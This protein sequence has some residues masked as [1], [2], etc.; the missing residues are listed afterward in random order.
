MGCGRW[1]VEGVGCALSTGFL[2]W[3]ACLRVRSGLVR[4]R[5]MG[6]CVCVCVLLQGRSVRVGGDVM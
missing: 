5:G 3:V 6:V 4:G 1:V 2:I